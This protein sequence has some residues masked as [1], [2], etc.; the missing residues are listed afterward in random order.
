METNTE[1]DLMYH[2]PSY[3]VGDTGM[4]AYCILRYCTSLI[5]A[6]TGLT[7]TFTHSASKVAFYHSASVPR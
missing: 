6:S 3:D 1:T 2:M 4:H 5:L 7:V